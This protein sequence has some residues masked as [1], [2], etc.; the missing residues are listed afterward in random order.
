MGCQAGLL[1]EEANGGVGSGGEDPR[2]RGVKG[3]VEDAEVVSDGVTSE[4]LHGDDQRVLQQVAEDEG[5]GVRTVRCSECCGQCS[6]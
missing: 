6:K 2:L 3:H 5:G 4:D 1:G